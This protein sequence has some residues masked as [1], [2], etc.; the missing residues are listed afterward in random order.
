MWTTDRGGWRPGGMKLGISA[1]GSA[2]GNGGSDLPPLQL[3][4]QFEKGNERL[5][6]VL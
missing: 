1:E 2:F 6:P 5:K 4:V 3:I